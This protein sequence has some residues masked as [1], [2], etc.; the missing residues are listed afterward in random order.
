[1][2]RARRTQDATHVYHEMILNT[3]D[4][5][6]HLYLSAETNDKMEEGRETAMYV[7]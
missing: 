6:L 5:S 4:L 2:V 7:V 1:M 3:F